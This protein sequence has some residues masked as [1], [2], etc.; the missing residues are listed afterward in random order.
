MEK[1]TFLRI[2]LGLGLAELAV[3]GLQFLHYYV[4]RPL[5]IP[6]VR[7]DTTG[8]IKASYNVIFNLVFYCLMT[9]VVFLLLRGLPGMP[10]LPKKTLGGAIVS[11]PGIGRSIGVFVLLMAV[12]FGIGYILGL[13]G[14]LLQSVFSSA[15]QSLFTPVFGPPVDYGETTKTIFDIIANILGAVVMAPLFEEYI[16]RR[17]VLDKLRPFGDV[18]AVVFSGLAFGLTHLNFGQFFFAAFLGMIFGYVMIKTNR[19]RYPILMHFVYNLFGTFSGILL[20]GLSSSLL[21]LFELIFAGYCIAVLIIGITVFFTNL[22]RIKFQRPAFRFSRPL[23]G[24]MILLNSGTAFAFIA[25]LAMFVFSAI[26]DLI[27]K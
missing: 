19:L 10:Q 22:K 18:T 11:R 27:L 8:F 17:L 20:G 5:V 6:F 21:A 16:F 15:M 24:K 25:Y 23:G 4:L 1:K 14:G 7:E 12:C 9:L 26:S 3:L 2:G 13:L